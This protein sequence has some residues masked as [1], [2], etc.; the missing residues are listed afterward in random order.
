MLLSLLAAAALLAL[1]APPALAERDPID[2]G[3]PAAPDGTP[4]CA[5]WVHDRYVVH[6]PDGRTWP[7]WHPPRDP[8][9]GCAFGH[10]HGSSPRAFHYFRRTGMPA[11]GPIGDFAGSDE[12][13]AGFKVFVVNRDRKG[14]AWMM[15]L[16][17]GSA[18]PRR[19]TVRFHSLEIWLF[20]RRGGRLVA[21]T[22]HMADFGQAVPNCPD[23]A[24]P[25]TGMRL[26]PSPA[27][28]ATYEEWDTAFDVGGVFAGRP[29]F[30][31]DNA[32][33]QFDPADPTRIAFNKPSACG[34]HDPA[35]WNSRCKGD[36]RT[37]LHP[38]WVVR[39]R[40]RS[41]FRTDSYGRRAAAGLLQAVSRRI[42]VDQSDEC[43]GAEN[44]FIMEQ[45]SDGGIY[46]AGRGLRSASFEF[47][48]YCL[49]EPN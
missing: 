22:R 4:M 47:P 38:R 19:G 29:G 44:A 45:P 26:L 36:R 8:R 11:F 15:V 33:T 14:L 21:H 28:T 20:R 30:G 31:I 9:Y 3:R 12:P 27:C 2:H 32:I 40:G 49:L 34:P 46:R 17:Q 41:R 24:L 23:A 39:N 18:S 16:H 37:V 43:C 10:E 5:Q 13:H 25:K 35:G 42:R 7:T 1:A 48:G 6:T